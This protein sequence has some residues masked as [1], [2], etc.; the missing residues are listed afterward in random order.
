MANRESNANTTH[1]TAAATTVIKAKPGFIGRLVITAVGSSA[2]V[3]IYDNAS[4]G[5]GDVL[6]SWATADGKGSFA[7]E[8]RADNGIT[9]VVGGSPAGYVTWS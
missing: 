7:M 4:A 2:T 6:W 5:S 9:I 1:L 3:V 8:A